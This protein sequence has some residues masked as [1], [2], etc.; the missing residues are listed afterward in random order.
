MHAEVGAYARDQGIEAAYFVGDNSVEVAWKH[1][2]QTVCGLPKDPLIQ[3][4]EPR[5]AR[6]RH[7]VISSVALYEDGRS[8]RGID[9]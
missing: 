2:A 8:G 3:A 7:Q 4:L 1:L 6:T 5:F 9:G